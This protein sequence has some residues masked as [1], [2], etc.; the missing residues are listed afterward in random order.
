MRVL[1]DLAVVT[2]VAAALLWGCGFLLAWLVPRSYRPLLPLL[3]PYLGLALISAVGHYASA[4]GR[5][6]R[7]VLWLFIALAAAGWAGLV[8]NRRLRRFPRS[9]APILAVC[10][11]AFA[12]AVVPLL[13]LGYLTTLGTA[14]DGISYAVRSE[15][16]QDAPF[17][18]PDIAAGKP[19]LGW[20]R[21]QIELIRAGD[22]M[23]VG[24]LGML[25]RRRSFELLSVVPALFFALTAGSVYVWTRVSLRLGRRGALL[26]AILTGLSNLLLWPVYDNFL[27]QAI[28]VGLI[29]WCSRSAPRPSAGRIGGPP[30]SSGSSWAPW[31]RS[32]RSMP[33][34]PWEW[35]SASGG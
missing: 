16:L 22:V 15:Y 23:L 3:A 13:S 8:F 21:G 6:L 28:A 35:S 14:I 29:P 9:S 4:A 11:L 10:L 26:A 18:L 30:P 2:G 20:V 27:S 33:S 19:Y 24:V 5:P 31:S 25:T 1:L 7:S 32:I 17:G 12:L 34:T